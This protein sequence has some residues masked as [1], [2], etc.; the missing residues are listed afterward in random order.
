MWNID[1]EVI[2]VGTGGIG[3]SVLS[4]TFALNCEPKTALKYKGYYFC[5]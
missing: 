4:S 5:E 2:R 1:R 3:D